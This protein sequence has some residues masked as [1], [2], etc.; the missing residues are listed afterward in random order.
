M[1]YIFKRHTC[2]WNYKLV[3]HEKHTHLQTFYIKTLVHSCF[4]R[5]LKSLKI[6]NIT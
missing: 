4:M 2:T 1:K 3:P 6:Q 5:T